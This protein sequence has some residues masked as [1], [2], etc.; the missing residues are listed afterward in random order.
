MIARWE[1]VDRDDGTTY[2]ERWGYGKWV[3]YDDLVKLAK[4][5]LAD[6]GLSDASRVELQ[7]IVQRKR[8]Q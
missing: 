1:F 6:P 7:E 2:M 4:W 5:L 3:L 8:R